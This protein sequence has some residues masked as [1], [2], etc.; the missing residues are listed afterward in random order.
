[1]IIV[2]AIRR[3]IMQ[4]QDLKNNL[5]ILV[6]SC[7]SYED[8]WNP[9]FTLLKKYWPTVSDIPIVLNTESKN[10]AFDG[11]DIICCHSVAE[12]R[13]GQRMLN[14]LSSIRTKYV[15]LLLDDFFLRKPVSE[16]KLCQILDW[17]EKD[18]DIA[19]FN[20]ESS[21]TYTGYEVDKY[22]G[23]K[24]I[25]PAN[26][27]TLNMQAAI[28]QTEILRDFWKPSASPWEW[29]TIYNPLILNYPNYKFYCTTKFENS[30]LDY[31]HYAYGD[32]WGVYRG[33]WVMDDVEPLFKKENINVD[34]S[35]RGFYQTENINSSL[36][37]DNIYSNTHLKNS[38]IKSFSDVCARLKK[39]C[40]VRSCLELPLYVFFEAYR[41]IKTIATKTMQDSYFTY[42]LK[43]ERKRFMSSKK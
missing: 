10:F 2:Y 1:M 34:F 26:D 13:Y 42:L 25:P 36:S 22:P 6:C 12:K 30:F 33:K 5:T 32:I 27:F 4:K 15:L 17:M 16:E 37:S 24:R 23:F 3:I 28:W 8:L 11:L 14:T 18:K 35:I 19:Y 7:D 40:E 29:E 41:I 21:Y 20:C 31:G 38:T 9:F 43:K 39:F